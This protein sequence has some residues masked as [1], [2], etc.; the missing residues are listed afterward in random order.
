M[1]LPGTLPNAEAAGAFENT[2]SRI[3]AIERYR[4]TVGERVPNASL[5]DPGDAGR[6]IVERRLAAL[7]GSYA[8]LPYPRYIQPQSTLA[9]GSGYLRSNFLPA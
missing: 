5:W 6:S 2:E 3:S 1:T 8:L 7:V 9:T 4:Q